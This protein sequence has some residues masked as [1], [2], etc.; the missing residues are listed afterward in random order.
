VRACVRV[1][2]VVMGVAGCCTGQ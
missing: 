2:E 1:C